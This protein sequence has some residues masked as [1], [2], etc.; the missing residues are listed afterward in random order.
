MKYST[1]AR[2]AKQILKEAL[3]EIK[4]I[5]FEVWVDAGECNHTPLNTGM[6]EIIPK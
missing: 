4:K 2:I 6:V 5:G 3:A 1:D